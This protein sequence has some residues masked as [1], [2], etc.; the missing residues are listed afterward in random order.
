MQD[1]LVSSKVSKTQLF[2]NW[3]FGGRRL[4]NNFQSEMNL[5]FQPSWDNGYEPLAIMDKDH[6]GQLVGKE[7]SKLGLWFD[8]NQDALAQDGEIRSLADVSVT[9]VFYKG[10]KRNP[11]SGDLVLDVGYERKLGDKIVTGKSFDWFPVIGKN[12]SEVQ[13]Q[14]NS[15]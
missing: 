8:N 6:D 14:L 15:K 5:A 7:L 10:S 9:K 11:V 12:K 13:A 4:V 1:G 2:G 3:T